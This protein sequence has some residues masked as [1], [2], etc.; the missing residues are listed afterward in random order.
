MLNTRLK[1]ETSEIGFEYRIA[2]AAR[3]WSGWEGNGESRRMKSFELSDGSL[4]RTK[5]LYHPWNPESQT[6]RSY[7]RALKPYYFCLA[8]VKRVTRWSGVSGGG[9][10]K[11]WNWN[12]CG[13]FWSDIALV[14]K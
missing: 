4:S 1:A 13:D 8:I 7:E 6:N 2:A 14:S 10:W 5:I 11:E 12:E 9:S 3:S